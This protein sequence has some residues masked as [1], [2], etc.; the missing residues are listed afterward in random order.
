MKKHVIFTAS[1]ARFGGF[2][3]RHWLTSLQDHVDL[4]DVD[5]VVLDYGMTDGQRGEAAA[6]GVICHPSVKDWHVT[7]ARYRDMAAVLESADYDQVMQ[8]DGGDIIFQA[9][10]RHLF[11]E[12]TDSFRGVCHEMEVPFHEAI[13]SR[14]DFAPETYRRIAEFLH[15]KPTINGGLVMGPAAK[16]KQIWSR[17]QEHTQNFSRFGIDQFLINFIFHKDGYVELDPK[18]NY[19]IIAR[20]SDYSVRDGVFYDAQ[21]EAIPIV[22]NSGI[23]EATRPIRNFGYGPEYNK[24]RIMVPLVLRTGYRFFNFFRRDS[25]AQKAAGHSLG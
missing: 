22:H 20:T 17:W 21:G 10:I 7:N 4:S 18:Y 1:D 15:D 23:Y 8:A 2:F 24:R 6:R 5:V 3:L 11:D 14:G 16:M 25:V 12:H 13:M 19:S 9:D